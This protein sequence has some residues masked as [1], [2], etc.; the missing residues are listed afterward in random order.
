MGYQGCA[1]S[2]RNG[3][4]ETHSNLVYKQVNMVKWQVRFAIELSMY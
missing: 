3:M 4:E 1:S 2:D